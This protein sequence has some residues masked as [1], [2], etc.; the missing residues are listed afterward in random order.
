MHKNMLSK[1][2]NIVAQ[3]VICLQQ[4]YIKQ[5]GFVAHIHFELEGCFEVNHTNTINYGKINRLLSS[6]SIDGELVTEYWKNQWEFVS[7][8]NGQSPLKEAHNLNFIITKLPKLIDQYC[9]QLGITKTLIRPVVWSGDRGKLAQGC[10]TI[11]AADSREVH[12]PNAIQVNVSVSELIGDKAGKNIVAQGDFG[13][14]LQNYFLQTSR[15]CCLLYLPED[16]AFERLALKT[17]YGLAKEL[18]SPIDI[19]GG[20]QGS[21]ALYRQK[22]KHNQPLGLKPLLYGSDHQIILSEQNWHKTARIEHR[23]GASSVYYNSFVNVVFA[24]AN[25]IAALENDYVNRSTPEQTKILNSLPISLY[26][27]EKEWGA[28]ELFS[29]DVWFENEINKVQAK[30]SATQEKTQSLVELSNGFGALSGALGTQL[31]AQILARYILPPI[32]I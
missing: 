14:R 25:V 9:A 16:E 26:N 17:K 18:C 20:H 22:G 21:I 7:H 11:F 32:Q 10:E 30:M 24:L 27:S 1:N 15:A 3:Q 31:K 29:Q 13:E 28:V 8:F 4:A 6:L 5:L 23:L 19:S 12:I 2:I